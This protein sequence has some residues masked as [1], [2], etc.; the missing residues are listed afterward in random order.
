LEKPMVV[1]QSQKL[2]F[3]SKKENAKAHQ[4]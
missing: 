4:C 3:I 2:G 1:R